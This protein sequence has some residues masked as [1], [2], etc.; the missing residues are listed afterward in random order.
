MHRL[1]PDFTLFWL[2]LCH[3]SGSVAMAHRT[4]LQAWNKKQRIPGYDNHPH[5]PKL[6]QGWSR[7][8]LRR[9]AAQRRTLVLPR[10]A[11]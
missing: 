8:N 6:P 3:E 5:W 11:A 10:S 1:P 9:I 4:L 2:G 7:A